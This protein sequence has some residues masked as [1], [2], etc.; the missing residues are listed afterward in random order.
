MIKAIRSR[1]QTLAVL[2]AA[3][4]AAG[5]AVLA[6]FSESAVTVEPVIADLSRSD[7]GQ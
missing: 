1:G 7:E 5:A 4:H 2:H 3:T 6:A